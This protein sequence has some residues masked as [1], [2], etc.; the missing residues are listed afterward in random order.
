[1]DLDTDQMSRSLNKYYGW[2]GRLRLALVLVKVGSLRVSGSGHNGGRVL[3]LLWSLLSEVASS[4]DGWSMFSCFFLVLSCTCVGSSVMS[5]SL[6]ANV[7]A[8]ILRFFIVV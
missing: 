1:M 5:R 8:R 7:C 3:L 4:F 2:L 6:V